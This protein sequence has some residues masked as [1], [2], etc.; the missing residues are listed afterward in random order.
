MA[1][2]A[3]GAF[4]SNLPKPSLPSIGWPFSRSR[5]RM[6]RPN[7]A[8]EAD[9]LDAA[10]GAR[11]TAR[12]YAAGRAGVAFEDPGAASALWPIGPYHPGRAARA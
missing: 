1:D 6:A 4:H 10:R 8:T 3:V 7:H 12:P 9:A 2:S 11:L 5:H